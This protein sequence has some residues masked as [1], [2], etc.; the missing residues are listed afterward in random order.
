MTHCSK[1]SVDIRSLNTGTRWKKIVS[2]DGCLDKGDLGRQDENF[3][4][5]L[6]IVSLSSWK[7]PDLKVGNINIKWLSAMSCAC[8]YITHM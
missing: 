1:G 4:S 6:S 2:R 7:V 3:L 5:F 8:V